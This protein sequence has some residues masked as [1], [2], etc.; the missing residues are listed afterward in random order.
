M[1]FIPLTRGLWAT[2]DDEDYEGLNQWKWCASPG[3]NTF[4]AAR[5]SPKPD[6]CT[7]LMHREIMDRKPG[8]GSQID[9]IDGYG[10][11]NQKSNLRGATHSQN[12][13]NQRPTLGSSR[14]KGV[15][16]KSAATKWQVHIC[17]NGK[18]KSLGYFDSEEDAARTYDAAALKHFGEFARLNLE[19]PV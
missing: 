5:S 10:L 13:M 4:Y 14:F 19:V 15:S 1:R 12:L 9:H 3:T 6:R 11:N 16:W 8:D 18:Q 2:V 7:I 17:F